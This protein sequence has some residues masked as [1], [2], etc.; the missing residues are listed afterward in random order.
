MK[1]K[2]VVIVCMVVFIFFVLFVRYILWPLSQVD[3]NKQIPL[4]QK[5]VSIN[6]ASKHEAFFLPYVRLMAVHS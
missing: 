4:P 2:D 6:K 1:K 5:I 3:K